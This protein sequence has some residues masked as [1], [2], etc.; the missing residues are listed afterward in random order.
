MAKNN[1]LL[2]EDNIMLNAVV[3]MLIENKIISESKL[4]K[5]MDKIKIERKKAVNVNMEKEF[6][7]ILRAK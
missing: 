7:E 6:E 4:I 5:R 3:D 2:E 1:E